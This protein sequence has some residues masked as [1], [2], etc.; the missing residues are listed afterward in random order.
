MRITLSDFTLKALKITR[1]GSIIYMAIHNKSGGIYALKSIRKSKVKQHLP[2]F[3]MQLKLGL[4]AN[5]PNINKIY[6]FFK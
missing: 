3:L 5:H 6:G 2:E 4:C 1:N